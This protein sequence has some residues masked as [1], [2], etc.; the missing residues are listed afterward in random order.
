M[1]EVQSYAAQSDFGMNL[2]TDLPPERDEKFS[3]WCCLL[4]ES[5]RHS[6]A[7]SVRPDWLFKGRYQSQLQSNIPKVH[8]SNLL[9]SRTPS[10]SKASTA[11]GKLFG[12]RWYREA[13]KKTRRDSNTRKEKEIFAFF[14]LLP[15]RL[16]H[17]KASNKSKQTRKREPQQ[18]LNTASTH[19]LAHHL[20]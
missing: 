15:R 5:L 9:R 18:S 19:T 2:I 4:E 12:S 20:H 16:I 3:R 13:I 10:V 11:H 6:T 7:R 1:C 14:F 8:D 17:P